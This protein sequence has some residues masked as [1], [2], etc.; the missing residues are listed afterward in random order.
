MD[1]YPRLLLRPKKKKAVV[2][3]CSNYRIRFVNFRQ[4]NISSFVY[5]RANHERTVYSTTFIYFLSIPILIYVNLSSNLLYPTLVLVIC[6]PILVIWSL[7]HD[8]YLTRM[9]AFSASHIIYYTIGG[10]LSTI[11]TYIKKKKAQ[12]LYVALITEYNL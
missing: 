11:V 2:V 8:L 9:H 6:H 12:Q 4:L 1:I 3:C 7:I 10:Y 5:E